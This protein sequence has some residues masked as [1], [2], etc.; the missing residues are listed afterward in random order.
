MIKNKKDGLDKEFEE[1]FL[2]QKIRYKNN[3]TNLKD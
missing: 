3:I 2:L 1:K